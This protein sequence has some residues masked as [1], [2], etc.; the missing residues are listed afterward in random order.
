MIFRSASTPLQL[1]DAAA[2]DA[3][4]RDHLIE[5]PA[6]RRCLSAL[7]QQLEEPIVRVDE[8]HVRGQRLRQGSPR[9][10]SGSSRRSGL[11]VRSKEMTTVPAAALSGTNRAAGSDWV[12]RPEPAW[13]SRPSDV[14]V[15][16]AGETQHPIAARRRA[17][18]ADGRPRRLV[19]RGHAQHLQPPPFGRSALPL[20]G[21]TS[22]GWV[23]RSSCPSSPPV[24]TAFTISGW[25]CPWY[26]GT[27]RADNSRC[28]GCRPPR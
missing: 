10:R 20:P 28:S 16:G 18:Q 7:A 13:A 27:P 24:P 15:V 14:T 23:R 11:G 21:S 19:P 12:A 5:S 8:T 9:A 1:L 2:G 26:Q 6:V 25:A 3:K 17:R 4:A 22:P